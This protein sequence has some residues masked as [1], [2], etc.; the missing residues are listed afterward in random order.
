MTHAASP[1]SSD[2]AAPLAHRRPGWL[3]A[4]HWATAVAILVAVALVLYRDTV[5]DKALRALLLD[6]H[7]QIGLSVM[8]A[9]LLRLSLRWRVPPLPEDT[10]APLVR[11]AAAA[12]HL[13][14]YAL[15]LALPLLGWA[16]F[17]SRGHDA[18][19][20]GALPLPR[21]VE[22]DPDLADTLA[23]WHQWVAWTL[24]AVSGLHAVAALWHHYVRGDAVLRA[25]LPA[26]LAL[27]RG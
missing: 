25:M 6:I 15:M 12:T 18:T 14:L 9:T 20:L 13:L 3:I 11:L 7:R 24:L 4:V 26:R 10:T 16:L 19:L 23:D 8:L 1:H 27:R 21:L 17:N 2:T 5:D 22:T